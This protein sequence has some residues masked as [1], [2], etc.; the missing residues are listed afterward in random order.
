MGQLVN[1]IHLF[2]GD[3]FVA[4]LVFD[5]WT[6]WILT[7]A[8]YNWD[9][10]DYFIQNKAIEDITLQN[11]EQRF[12]LEMETVKKANSQA[13]GIAERAAEARY[14]QAHDNWERSNSSGGNVVGKHPQLWRTMCR[15]SQLQLKLRMMMRLNH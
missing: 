10:F 5:I 9:T 8:Y 14:Q 15:I 12:R 1:A 13:R 4:P 3:G 2:E 11:H 6:K 7:S